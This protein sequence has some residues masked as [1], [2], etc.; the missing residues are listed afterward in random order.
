MGHVYSIVN[1]KN[2]GPFYYDPIGQTNDFLNVKKKFPIE[3]IIY[4]GSAM[5]DGEIY[6][7]RSY[8]KIGY[9]PEGLDELRQVV[10]YKVLLLRL[11]NILKNLLDCQTLLDLV[12]MKLIICLISKQKMRLV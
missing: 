6:Q 4:C 9:R 3:G 10:N 2:E 11:M 5:D 12:C 7:E 8:R 1:F